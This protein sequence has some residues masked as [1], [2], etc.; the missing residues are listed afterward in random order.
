M[1]VLQLGPYPPPEGGISRNI[2]AIREELERRGHRCSIIATSRSVAKREESGVY[3]PQ[4]A[5]GLLRLL[6]SIDHDVLHLHVGGNITRRVLALVFACGLWRRGKNILSFHSGGYPHTREGKR[7]RRTSLQGWLFRRFARVIAVSPLI[8]DV[9][10]RYG[11][12]NDRLSVIQPFVPKTPDP[13]VEIPAELIEFAQKANPLLLSVCLLEPEYDLFM[14]IDAMGKLLARF[15]DAGL[16]IVGSGSL[17]RQLQKRIAV[18]PHRDRIM[19]AGN[20]EH[21]VTLHLINECDALLRT[22]LFDGDAIAIREALFLD[23]PVIA[24]DNGMRPEGVHL[25][26]INDPAALIAKIADV[27]EKPKQKKPSKV[28]NTSNIDAVIDIYAELSTVSMPR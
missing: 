28:A 26:P 1:H 4:S 19:L 16:L 6:F 2:L 3:H 8:A 27:V 5:F 13:N 9:F 7:A 22:T 18:K 21:A 20:V 17:K 25:I 14:Q 11:I 10:E 12:R 24:T 15:P 23:T